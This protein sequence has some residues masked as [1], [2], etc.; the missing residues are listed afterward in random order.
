MNK[1][2][3]LIILSFITWITPVKAEDLK[4]WYDAPPIIGWKPFR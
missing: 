4:L 2:L 3:L 1:H